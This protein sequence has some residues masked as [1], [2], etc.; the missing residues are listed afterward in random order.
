VE[1]KHSIQ[2]AIHMRKLIVLVLVLLAAGVLAAW[3]SGGTGRRAGH[4]SGGSIA[5][6]AD[7]STS[8]A[9]FSSKV[10]NLQDALTRESQQANLAGGESGA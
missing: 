6:I 1:G 5:A 8:W 10:P 4:T 3:A 9:E 2:E 7:A